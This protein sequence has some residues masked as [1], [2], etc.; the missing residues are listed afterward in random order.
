MMVRTALALALALLALASPSAH[1]AAAD[2]SK[3]LLD[4]LG[5]IDQVPPA[6]ALRDAAG[7]TPVEEALFRVAAD[8][9]LPDYPRRRAAM[10]LGAFP[11]ATARAYLETIAATAELQDLRWAA[12]YAF[13][14]SVAPQDL[15]AALAFAA[16]RLASPQ[17]LDREAVIRALRHVPGPAAEALV[18]KQQAADK[19]AAVQAAIR[20]FWLARR[21]P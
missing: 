9:E 17:P 20:R 14:R 4:H 12:I 21:A 2:H 10:L 16:Q 13:V 19:D 3:R 15:H 18:A 6:E 7:D 1:A 5:A 11:G 8:R